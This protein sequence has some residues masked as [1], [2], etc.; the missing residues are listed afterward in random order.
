MYGHMLHQQAARDFEGLVGRANTL[1]KQR[2]VPV[3]ED[4]AK[5]WLIS[6]N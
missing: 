5:L 4:F 1:L 6:E 2:E 3:G